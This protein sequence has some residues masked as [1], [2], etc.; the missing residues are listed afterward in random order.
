[1]QKSSSEPTPHRAA[2]KSSLHDP[3][4]RDPNSDRHSHRR[5]HFRTS[6]AAPPQFEPRLHP[7]L[8]PKCTHAY[9]VSRAGAAR[10]VRHLRSVSYYPKP[11]S[12]DPSWE[13]P[14][15]DHPGDNMP[16]TNHSDGAESGDDHSEAL[17]S[18]PFGSLGFAYG[19][20]FDQALVRLIQ[21]RRISAFSMVPSVIVQTKDGPSD[22]MPGSNGSAWKDVLNDSAL[23]RMELALDTR[24]LDR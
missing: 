9:A 16:G 10:L 1:M 2:E 8:T 13:Q 24:G 4:K 17:S 3:E 7:S 6:S 11:S 15:N 19:R 14:R 23:A 18:P 22:I 21:G 12:A 20:A 5:R